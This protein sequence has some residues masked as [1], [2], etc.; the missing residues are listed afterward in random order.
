[1]SQTQAG[2]N[3]VS[4]GGHDLHTAGIIV[5]DLSI[6]GVHI[7]YPL[8]VCKD[9]SHKIIIGMDF[10]LK[11][12][13]DLLFSKSLIRF[14]HLNV[15]TTLFPIEREIETE[16]IPK[17]VLTL[18]ND[19]ELPSYSKRAITVQSPWWDPLK[20]MRRVGF[21]AECP[22][23]LDH[24]SVGKGIIELDN[25]VTTIMIANLSHCL[26]QMKA[27]TPVAC[28]RH[29]C[30]E[31][32]KNNTVYSVNDIHTTDNFQLNSSDI[33]HEPYVSEVLFDFEK[34]IPLK[35]FDRFSAMSS[36]SEITLTKDAPFGIVV[37]KVVLDTEFKELELDL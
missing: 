1:M 30:V 27:D 33:F 11:D 36:K 26:V 5:V 18:V 17:V 16:L 20:Q 22:N 32:D 15:E 2:I 10:I 7:P 28:L 3:L 29:V 13:V 12:N 24:I 21:V 37:T 34:R 23:F 6:K 35:D 9:M 4:A 8:I 19:L 31:V 14:E 25:G